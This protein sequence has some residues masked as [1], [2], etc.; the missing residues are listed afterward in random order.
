MCKG[1]CL[2]DM[3]KRQWVCAKE[4]VFGI[5]SRG[6]GYVQRSMPWGYVQG[7]VG[8]GKGVCLWDMF[9]G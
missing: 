5:C 8:M 2:E 6:S 3:F 4:Y 1:I 7:V 9:K